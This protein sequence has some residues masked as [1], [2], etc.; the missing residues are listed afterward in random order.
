MFLSRA[1]VFIASSFYGLLPAFG[2]QPSLSVLYD[3]NGGSDGGNPYAGLVFGQ[4]GALYG[5]TSGVG[6]NGTVFQLTP[7]SKG[8]T[9]WTKTTL[10][11]FSSADGADPRSDLIFDRNGALYG[12]TRVGGIGNCDNGCG[13]VFKVTPPN[14]GQTTW[15]E[16]VLYEFTGGA[17]GSNPYG[18]VIIDK[19]GALYG[20]TQGGGINERGTVFSLTPPGKGQTTWTE[21]VLHYFTGSDGFAPL[22]GQLVADD[23]GTLYGTTTS[24][25]Y[26]GHGVVFSLT[27]P[28]HGQTT[29][30]QNV[31]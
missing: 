17:D 28:K 16:T 4:S 15:T 23:G 26:Y 5:T 18:G 11:S 6:D 19:N 21:T 20:T 9:A 12:T 2:Q 24:G 31:L 25:G 22:N 13:V 8:G 30:T 1:V 10:H 3:F 7:P 14:G 29:W 27:P